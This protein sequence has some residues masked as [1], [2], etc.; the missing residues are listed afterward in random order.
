M[1]NRE[2][3]EA[4]HKEE[5][6]NSTFERW[7]SISE[8]YMDKEVQARFEGYQAGLAAQAKQI[9]D[10]LKTNDEQDL[11]ISSLMSTAGLLG[12]EAQVKEI[13]SLRKQVEMLLGSARKTVLALAHASIHDPLYTAAYDELSESIKLASKNGDSK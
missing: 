10:L 13:E 3:F 11:L 5:F 4:W 6:P 7:M 9:A 12:S 8:P 1:N 2:A